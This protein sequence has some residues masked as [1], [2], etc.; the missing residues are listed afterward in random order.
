MSAEIRIG[1]L[2]DHAEVLPI[3]VHWFVTWWPE[4]YGPDG[5][6]D[7]RRDLAAYS[8]RDTL[9]IGVIAFSDGQLCGIAALKPDSLD[10]HRHLTPWA[11]AGLVAP[12]FRRRGIGGTLLTELER[13]ARR[14]GYPGL[15]CGTNTAD[16]LLER[17][18]W[19][20]FEQG[21]QRGQHVRIYRKT[22]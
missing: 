4:Y 22:L 18:G 1:Y 8:G 15:Y 20:C 21:L 19:E 12:S 9:P 16:S 17:N 7:A 10:T 6:G 5:P 13:I 11:A 14:L 3:L 2:V